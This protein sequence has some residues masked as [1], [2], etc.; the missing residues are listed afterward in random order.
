MPT[1]FQSKPVIAFDTNMLLAIYQLKVDVFGQARKLFGGNAK[2]VITEQIFTELAGLFETNSTMQK[3]IGIAYS[4]IEK[5]KVGIEIVKAGTAD[6]SLEEM[7]KKGCFVATNDAV[8]RKR[9]KGFGGKVIY[10]RQG[11]FLEI[12]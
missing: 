7:A 12:G 8:L 11:R 3:P 6:Q 2:L 10:L 5:N 9:I 4:Q 1:E